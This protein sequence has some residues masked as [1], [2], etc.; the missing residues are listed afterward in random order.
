MSQSAVDDGSD[1]AFELRDG[2][3]VAH[4]EENMVKVQAGYC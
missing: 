2:Y 1:R 4:M 3:V